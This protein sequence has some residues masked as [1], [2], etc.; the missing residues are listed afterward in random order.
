MK[1][2]KKSKMLTALCAAIM[3]ISTV[4]G[5]NV[6]ATTPETLPVEDIIINFTDIAGNAIEGKDGTAKLT[7][8]DSQGHKAKVTKL[9]DFRYRITDSE[10]LALKPGETYKISQSDSGDYIGSKIVFKLPE[11]DHRKSYSDNEYCYFVF[12]IRKF[13]RGDMNF[14]GIVDAKD[15][16]VMKN[17]ASNR[18][19]YT[20]TATKQGRTMSRSFNGRKA[21]SS[22]EFYNCAFLE[23][24][25][26]DYIST[27]YTCHVTEEMDS[28]GIGAPIYSTRK[29]LINSVDNSLVKSNPADVD[30]NNK[31]TANDMSCLKEY[32]SK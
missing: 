20:F 16:A 10:E 4:G 9:K 21:F 11:P 30:K 5:M 27:V 3:T 19:I 12:N 13:K 15:L 26:E 14:D 32:I 23:K 6:N 2:F 31:I 25:Q 8:T 22:P 29:L 7:F 17:V 28:A 1:V 24:I 18:G